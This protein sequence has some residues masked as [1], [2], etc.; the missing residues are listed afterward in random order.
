M[1]SR[2]QG[3]LISNLVFTDIKLGKG[4]DATVHE[5]EW[6]GTM[7]A[8]KR[9][10]DILLEDESPGGADKFISNF[11]TECLTWSKL[12]HPNVVQFLGV[13]LERG[14]RLPVLVIE[15]MDTSLRRYLE[16]HSK[17]KFPLDLK[18]FVLHQITQALAYLH[19]QNPPLVHHDL[20]TNNVLLNVVSFVTKL[21]DFGMS[22]AINPA[23][24]SRKSSIK[25][26]PAFMPPEALQT[27]L[28]YNEK[29]DVFS[30]GNVIL[31][32]ITHEWPQPCPST[33]YKGD[34][35]IALDEFQSRE[36]YVEMF[37]AQEKQ[38]FLPTLRCCLENQPD[39]CPSSVELVQELRRIESSLPVDGHVAA[40]IEQLYQQ[41][42]AKEEEC[43][44]KDVALRQ[45]D[46]VLKEKNSTILAQQDAIQE[47]KDSIQA[48]CT[49][50][51]KQRD[52]NRAQRT[53]I[54]KEQNTNEAL[55]AT[56]QAQ[57]V[58]IEEQQTLNQTHLIALRKQQDANLD[59]QTSL[60][61]Q[62][63]AIQAQQVEIERLRNQLAVTEQVSR[64]PIVSSHSPCLW[65]CV[66]TCVYLTC[67]LTICGN[68]LIKMT[69]L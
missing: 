6:N 66:H 45:K 32:T 10:H 52:T 49:A 20:S 65:F 40:P 29:L 30:F 67:N 1:S 53:A 38:L 12:R 13:Y 69:I 44:Q 21:T 57:Q 59:Q 68:V 16:N 31:S 11:E 41:L 55:R 5:V 26:T 48:L 24:I 60:Q 42:S 19:S 4:A 43:R 17:E 23:D 58:A 18:A 27:P 62:Q 50:I 51:Q 63:V 34:Q 3:L 37:T 8:S 7:C 22:R 2:F 15:K 28:R 33:R 35:L 36:R 39:K 61:S 25:G 9:L 14:S 54:Q 64:P 46:E 47:K 56:I